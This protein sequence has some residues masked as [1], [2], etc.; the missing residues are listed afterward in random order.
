[1]SFTVD[2]QHSALSVANRIV[3]TGIHARII[4]GAFDMESVRFADKGEEVMRSAWPP[5]L[6]MCVCRLALLLL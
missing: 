6:F 1:M 4:V 5:Y 3:A 2:Y